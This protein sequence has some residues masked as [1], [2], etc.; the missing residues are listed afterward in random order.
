MKNTKVKKW[1]GT[2]KDDLRVS[3]LLYQSKEFPHS[4]FYFQ[5]ATEKTVKAIC[6]YGEIISESD[7]KKFSH[8]TL[9]IFVHIMNSGKEEYNELINIADEEFKYLY[10]ESF[11]ISKD[12]IKLYDKEIERADSFYNLVKKSSVISIEPLFF[13]RIFSEIEEIK[14]EY[15]KLENEK[16]DHLKVREYLIE[17]LTF[18]CKVQFRSGVQEEELI[19]QIKKIGDELRKPEV[20]REFIRNYKLFKVN[21]FKLL[22][23]SLVLFHCATLTMHSASNTRYPVSN[24]QSNKLYSS[25]DEIVKHQFRMLEYLTEVIALIDSVIDSKI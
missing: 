13:E 7:L 23:S 25:T 19:S 17:Y 1:L 18:E 22:Y 24:S 6:L 8:D 12:D 4:Y 2:A 14:S 3:K 11:G 10:T 9:K 21:R 16:F 20:K 5:Q 15:L